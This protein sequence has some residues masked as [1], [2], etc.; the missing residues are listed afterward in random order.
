MAPATKAVFPIIALVILPALAWAGNAKF[1]GADSRSV[2][3]TAIAISDAPGTKET[4]LW[5][6]TRHIRHHI[7]LISTRSRS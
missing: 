4:R 6:R 1:S 3:E 5:K 2:F 7:H